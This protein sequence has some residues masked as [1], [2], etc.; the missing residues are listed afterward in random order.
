MSLPQGD[1]SDRTPLAAQYGAS[2]LLVA[3]ATVLAFAVEPLISAPNLTLIFVLPVVIAATALG[4][5]PSLVAVGAGV[6]AFDFFFTEPKYSFVIASPTD[7]WAAALLLI[8]AAIVS[9][10]AAGGRRR[11]MEARASADQAQ[12]LQALAHVIIEGR[13]PAEVVEAAAS[14]LNGIFRA[15]AVIF[16]PRGAALAAVA[17]AGGAAITSAEEDAARSALASRLPAHAG[18]YPYDQSAFDFWPVTT[19]S[20]A[21]CVLGVDF[22]RSGRDRPAAP[23]RFVEV[24]GAYLAAALRVSG[25][26]AG[27]DIRP[28]S[29]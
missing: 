23:E 28:S 18:A 21:I 27:A 5:G 3:A 4:W 19:P 26:T 2:L 10:V 20:G 11:T 12:A 24:I 1:A 16:M 15:P 7:A 17:S 6:L 29:S 14:A 8:T 9:T 13:P 22:T 25:Q